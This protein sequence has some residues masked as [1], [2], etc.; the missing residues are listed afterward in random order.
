MSY[1]I[2]QNE[3]IYLLGQ[4]FIFCFCGNHVLFNSYYIHLFVYQRSLL[5]TILY[6]NIRL[7]QQTAVHSVFPSCWL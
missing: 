4:K 7:H 3:F 2:L 1:I 6:K 5:W